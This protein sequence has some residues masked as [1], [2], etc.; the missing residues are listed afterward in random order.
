[1]ESSLTS[2]PW[3]TAL[4]EFR[5]MLLLLLSAAKLLPECLVAWVLS[6]MM[7]S[8]VHTCLMVCLTCWLQ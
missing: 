3:A 7:P 1:M 2:C 6:T 8:P 4:C 5:C